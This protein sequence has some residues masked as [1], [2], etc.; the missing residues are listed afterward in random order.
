MCK[1]DVVSPEEECERDV[2]IE[3]WQVKVACSKVRQ[4]STETLDYASPGCPLE[5][6]GNR[7]CDPLC[8]TPLSAMDG[9][10]CLLVETGMKLQF[11]QADLNGDGRVNASELLGFEALPLP[12]SARLEDFDMITNDRAGLDAYEFALL[13][14]QYDELVHEQLHGESDTEMKWPRTL[15]LSAATHI[16]LLGDKNIDGMLS[17]EEARAAYGISAQDFDMM[18]RLGGRLRPLVDAALPSR[19]EDMQHEEQWQQAQVN[20]LLIADMGKVMYGMSAAIAGDKWAD[21]EHQNGFSVEEAVRLAV[22]FADYNKDG[23]VS[24]AESALLAMPPAL[25]SVLSPGGAGGTQLALDDILKALKDVRACEDVLVVDRPGDISL[26][27]LYVPRGK[28]SLLFVPGWNVPA[29]YPVTQD[30]T[31]STVASGSSSQVKR[32]SSTD[33]TRGPHQLLAQESAVKPKRAMR[34]AR[35]ELMRTLSSPGKAKVRGYQRQ[36]TKLDS[37]HRSQS[38]VARHHLSSTALSG[39]T[40]NAKNKRKHVEKREHV[41]T[42]SEARPNGQVEQALKQLR[43]RF[44]ASRARALQR[45]R[46]TDMEQALVQS[47]EQSAVR[48]EQR[49]A[50]GRLR[51]L[52]R[53]SADRAI[54]TQSGRMAHTWQSLKATLHEMHASTEHSVRHRRLSR[55]QDVRDALEARTR[56]SRAL[57]KARDVVKDNFKWRNAVSSSGLALASSEA[58]LD[59]MPVC[60]RWVGNEY[61][62]VDEEYAG[63]ATGGPESCLKTVLERCPDAPLIT[64]KPGVAEAPGSCWCQYSYCCPENSFLGEPSYSMSASAATYSTVWSHDISVMPNDNATWTLSVEVKNLG[65]ADLVFGYAGCGGWLTLTATVGDEWTL[66]TASSQRCSSVDRLDF[67]LRNGNCQDGPHNNKFL[68]GYASAGSTSY[69][70][71]QEAWAV[72]VCDSTAG[73]VVKLS[74]GKYQ[75]RKGPNLRDSPAGE[76]SWKKDGCKCSTASTVGTVIF[77]NV[78]LSKAPSVPSSCVLATPPANVCSAVLEDEQSTTRVCAIE[79][80]AYELASGARPPPK[81]IDLTGE[82]YKT[83]FE[84]L[85]EM[86]NETAMTIEQE[87]QLHN[88]YLVQ[89]GQAPVSTEAFMGS[90]VVLGMPLELADMLLSHMSD[91]GAAK[92][93]MSSPLSSRD[94]SFVARVLND[95]TLKALTMNFTL[96]KDP[97]AGSEGGVQEDGD[98]VTH[99]MPY[100]GFPWTAGQR[101]VQEMDRDGDGRISPHETCISASDFA[102]IASF[103]T[104]KI[105]PYNRGDGLFSSHAWN[106]TG[107]FDGARRSHHRLEEDF[108]ARYACV[109]LVCVSVQCISY[110]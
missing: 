101:V 13:L 58:Q 69:N 78:H 80:I 109:G 103:R 71:L 48:R 59:I 106:G 12:H 31:C 86:L 21:S 2:D 96:S 93:E 47:I 32:Q 14:S 23:F 16:V 22:R 88:Y 77:R 36:D 110:L 68:G 55:R 61:N 35:A 66:L 65:T 98:V 76:I 51:T 53:H 73:G 87:M 11:V 15:A 28:C 39:W 42:V 4:N 43:K 74:G 82:E 29:D 90:M 41:A 56:R 1:R 54:M 108:G 79:N 38:V 85:P 62:T 40:T 67:Q 5:R 10:D 20:Q 7:M 75:V 89:L 34:N 18:L 50:L 25:F 81:A 8:M 95:C 91:P 63:D 37:S 99:K 6:I 24:R 9:G 27:T 94:F 107:L 100:C 84:R 52:S 105:R 49:V 97:R 33:S 64:Y 19:G 26:K 60:G 44:P 3:N 72:A 70:S 45:S 104:R 17:L 46:R 102:K 92:E 57:A 30:P 83:L